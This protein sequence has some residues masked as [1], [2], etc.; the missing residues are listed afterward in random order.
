MELPTYKYIIPLIAPQDNVVDGQA[1]LSPALMYLLNTSYRQRSM[2][3]FRFSF[4]FGEIPASDFP[5]QCFFL[6]RD[7]LGFTL[8]SNGLYHESLLCVIG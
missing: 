8:I 7:G 2:S 6:K 5:E 4:S 1:G 3:F